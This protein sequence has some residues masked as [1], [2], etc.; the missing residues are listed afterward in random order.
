VFQARFATVLAASGEAER[1]VTVAGAVVGLIRETGSARM[2][3]A[4][5]GVRSAMRP[6]ARTGYGRQMGEMTP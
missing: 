2:K 4:L 1:A 3:T 5:L 6:W